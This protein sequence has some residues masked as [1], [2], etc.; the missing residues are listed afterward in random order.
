MS[1]EQVEQD[2]L[3]ETGDI[4]ASLAETTRQLNEKLLATN[5]R[6]DALQRQVDEQTALTLI[7]GHK[8]GRRA[9]RI[10][11]VQKHFERADRP[12]VAA[13]VLHLWQWSTEVAGALAALGGDENLRPSWSRDDY[14]A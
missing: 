9:H 11:E 12:E 7:I 13:A 14:Q 10:S 3:D 8:L 5:E 2:L 6:I 1:L 4:R